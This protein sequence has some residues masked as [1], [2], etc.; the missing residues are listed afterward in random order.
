MKRLLLSALCVLTALV[1]ALGCACAESALQA[2]YESALQL[3]M[4]GKYDEAIEAFE[5]LRAYG[6]AADMI[7]YCRAL[8]CAAEG[9]L[10]DAILLMKKADTLD[11]ADMASYYEAQLYEKA[12]DRI[13]LSSAEPEWAD[14]ALYDYRKAYALYSALDTFLDSAERASRCARTVNEHDPDSDKP[15]LENRQ[16][17]YEQAIELM[18]AEKWEEAI[19]AFDQVQGFR[20]S[21]V[22]QQEC[23]YLNAMN[24][25][26][27]GNLGDAIQ[28]FSGIQKYRDAADKVS[29]LREL[30]S[31]RLANNDMGTFGL[32]SDGTVLYAG[33]N[34]YGLTKV[35]EWTNV[36]YI[37]AAG[38]YVVGI[39]EDGTV[40][41]AGGNSFGQC[42]VQDWTD[43]IAVSVNDDHVIGLRK[44]GTVVAA[45][46]NDDGQCD[47][48][49][50]TDI[51]AIDTND[52]HT[53]GLKKDGSVVAIGRN[54]GKQCDVSDWIDAKEVQSKSK[55]I[56]V[57]AAESESDDPADYRILAVQAGR[58]HTVALRKNGTLI[59]TGY[60]TDEQ[61]DTA[62]WKNIISI[63]TNDYSTI[64]LKNDGTAVA[65]G[66]NDNGQCDVSNWQ[67]I[68]SISA[69]PE[70][71]VCVKKD[72]TVAA[73]GY[74]AY[75]QCEVKDWEDVIFALAGSNV[76]VGMKK[77]GTVV[78]VGNNEYGQCDVEGWQ[79]W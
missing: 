32:R 7:S 56:I 78:A 9:N 3:M 64:G 69:S 5:A 34:L 50:W 6:N 40:L 71:T 21:T 28:Q 24:D 79:L 8:A 73:T 49:G 67:N 48:Q 53:V 15:L 65:V 74:N 27:E 10:D 47:V 18:K 20:A 12:A 30:L 54:D 22:K 70:H 38:T 45:G 51:T 55:E 11:S 23:R 77:D 26:A 43:I 42:D 60:N 36:T 1:L 4:D 62:E 41:A 59:T 2:Q 63:Q 37:A 16:E 57:V 13:D 31:G 46:N 33:T 52:Y 17:I 14:T 58:V 72:G 61:C 68:L 75:D 25:W 44:D 29:A 35:S 19:A 66:Y 76:T 39:R